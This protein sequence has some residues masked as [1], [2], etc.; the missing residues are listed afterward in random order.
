MAP[1]VAF[2]QLQTVKTMALRVRQ[3]SENAMAVAT[4]LESHPKVSKAVYPGLASFPQKALADRIHRGIHGG[5]LWMEVKGGVETGK[6]LMDTIPRP[7]TLG[8]NLGATES[9]IT[10]CACMTHATMLKEDREK[11][12]I[13]DGFVRLSCGIEDKEDLIRALKIALDNL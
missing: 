6:K 9:I 5:M 7:W 8:E 3:Q 13:T 2:N 4:F 10:A 11:I 12:G 1:Q